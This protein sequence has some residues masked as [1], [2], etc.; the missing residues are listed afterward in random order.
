M[1]GFTRFPTIPIT[2]VGMSTADWVLWGVVMGVIVLVTVISAFRWNL[3]LRHIE[4]ERVEEERAP[5]L[6]AA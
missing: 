2:H 4:E 1:L 5:V 3:R 6:K